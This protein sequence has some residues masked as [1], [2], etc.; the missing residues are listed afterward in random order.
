MRGAGALSNCR[1]PVPN[2]SAAGSLGGRSSAVAARVGRPVANVSGGAVVSSV[3]ILGSMEPGS[4]PL[5][6]NM[7]VDGSS[8][9]GSSVSQLITDKNTA[10]LVIFVP[11][12]DTSPV[13]LH[14]IHPSPTAPQRLSKTRPGDSWSTSSRW[15]LMMRFSEM[16][17]AERWRGPRSTGRSDP[18]VA[19]PVTAPLDCY[20]RK[21][22]H[23]GFARTE[24][25]CNFPHSSRSDSGSFFHTRCGLESRAAQSHGVVPRAW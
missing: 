18:C 3:A 23:G 8:E 20:K 25:G 17:S 12:R 4:A 9:S 19:S 6:W 22:D 2:D 13:G 24:A 7:G 14:M 21:T 11:I 16:Q 15:R 5:F 1:A 10:N